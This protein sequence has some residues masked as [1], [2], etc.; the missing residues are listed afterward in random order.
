MFLATYVGMSILKKI[1]SDTHW[2]NSLKLGA[3]VRRQIK[4]RDISYVQVI[5]SLAELQVLSL[6]LIDP[7][8]A[9]FSTYFVW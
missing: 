4:H 9:P 5:W 7:S 1:L 2:D 6:G 8:S 3:K